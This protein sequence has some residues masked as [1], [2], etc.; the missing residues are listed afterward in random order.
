MQ[1]PK[2][3]IQK[4]THEISFMSK[5]SLLA[6]QFYLHSFARLRM[7]LL[8]LVPLAILSSVLAAPSSYVGVNTPSVAAWYP[9]WLGNNWP[10]SKIS[11]SKYT[12]MKFAFVYVYSPQS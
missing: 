10:P 3:K 5:L 7:L 4:A 2:R 12:T 1:R 11:W 8:P 6:S 9:A